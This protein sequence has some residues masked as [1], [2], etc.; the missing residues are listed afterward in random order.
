MVGHTALYENEET[1]WSGRYALIWIL[2]AGSGSLLYAL[3]EIQD[4]S[5][6]YQILSAV[7]I[8]VSLIIS[9]TYASTWMAQYIQY[10]KNEV[11][12]RR[13]M[14]YKGVAQHI[15]SENKLMV[16]YTN[17]R[18][19][20]QILETPVLIDALRVIEPGSPCAVYVFEGSVYVDDFYI[21]PVKDDETD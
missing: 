11:I 21:I 2:C 9:M 20:E 18:G 10:N 5:L 6:V 19:E 3:V 12:L 16:V 4:L 7:W 17:V 13:G 1:K 15:L 14:R 8:V